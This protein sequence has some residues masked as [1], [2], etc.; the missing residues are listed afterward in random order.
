MNESATA[1]MIE[2]HK[3]FLI[4]LILIN[5]KYSDPMKKLQKDVSPELFDW[6]NIQTLTTS[7]PI[8]WK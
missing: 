6:M 1:E 8:F 5:R 4:V 2:N 3:H 7:V